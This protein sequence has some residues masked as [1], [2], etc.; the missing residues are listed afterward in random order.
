MYSGSSSA[1]LQP[2]CKSEP[3][4]EVSNTTRAQAA[5]Q[6]SKSQGIGPDLF[7][8]S[9]FTFWPHWVACG[10][11][12]PPPETELTPPISQ[13]WG[14]PLDHQRSLCEFSFLSFKG[15]SDDHHL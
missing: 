15:N 7:V 10:I 5:A 9:M 8:F 12:V 13:A 3:P 6:T 14:Q 4:V 2:S 1:I 11:L